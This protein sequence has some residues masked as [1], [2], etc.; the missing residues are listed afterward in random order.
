MNKCIFVGRLTRDPE[1]SFS[2]KAQ[3]SVARFTLAV[4]RIP[5]RE[6]EPEADFFNCVAFDRKAEFVEQYWYSG[7]RV[8]VS[9][10]LQNENYTNKK[11]EKVYGVSLKADDV[12]FADGKKGVDNGQPQTQS[13]ASTNTAAAQTSGTTAPAS[14][15][16]APTSRAAAPASRTAAPASRAAAPA[17]R[18]AAPASNQGAAKPAA[19]R[20]TPQRQAPGRS[21]TGRSASQRGAARTAAS[22]GFMNV[23]SGM[24]EGLPFN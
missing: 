16:A 19:G 11:G 21:A 10:K 14:R 4:D 6:G 13:A 18:A 12:E 24:E 15:T 20:S 5:K 22:D 9:G 3:M 1:V 17:S 8:A 23:A 2:E 7:M